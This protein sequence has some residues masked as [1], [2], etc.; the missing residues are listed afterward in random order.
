MLLWSE[1]G[2]CGIHSEVAQETLHEARDAQRAEETR[3]R[4][5]R[6]AREV[7]ADI[8]REGVDEA[9]RDIAEQQHRYDARA[10][11]ARR[12][13]ARDFRIFVHTATEHDT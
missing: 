6:A 5:A 10:R 7:C 9:V 13:S 11:G 3:E 2:T 1:H 12:T 4:R 8:V